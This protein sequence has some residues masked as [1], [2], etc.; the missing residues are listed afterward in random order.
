[1]EYEA[2]SKISTYVTG[3]VCVCFQNGDTNKKEN[4]TAGT[5]S[6]PDY[7]ALPL[8]KIELNHH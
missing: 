4:G 8:P 6:D 3:A 2:V 7:R 5:V 1:M